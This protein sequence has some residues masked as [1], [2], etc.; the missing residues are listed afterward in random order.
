[1]VAQKQ[2]DAGHA[3]PVDPGALP[4]EQLAR[5]KPPLPGPGGL[6]A[7]QQEVHDLERKVEDLEEK[8]QTLEAP[9]AAAAVTPPGPAAPQEVLREVR[10]L[11]RRVG[12]LNRL[13]QII[14]TLQESEE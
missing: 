4:P 7:I 1:M 8:V 6:Q 9:P 3:Q 2:P 10:N 12:G 11:A 5:A 14:A 13:S